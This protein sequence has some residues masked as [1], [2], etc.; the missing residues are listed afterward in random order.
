MQ[1]NLCQILPLYICTFTVSFMSHLFDLVDRSCFQNTSVDLIEVAKL[2]FWHSNCQSHWLSGQARVTRKIPCLVISIIAHLRI[3]SCFCK[4]PVI[5][6]K[7]WKTALTWSQILPQK[8]RTF[9]KIMFR[10]VSEVFSGRQFCKQL[11]REF[12]SRA[13]SKYASQVWTVIDGM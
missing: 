2:D 10:A 12:S 13:Q 3:F 5:F 4:F 11:W 6:I 1:I 9:R 8:I 7:V